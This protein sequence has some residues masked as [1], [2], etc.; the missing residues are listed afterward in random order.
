[1]TEVR[2]AASPALR[3]YQLSDNLAAQSGQVFLTG[4]QALVRLLL[5]QKAQDERQGLQTAGFVSGYRGSPLG[6]VDQQLWKAKKFLEKAEVNFLP[7]INEDLAA[8]AC[9]GVQRVA[10]DPKRTVDGVFAM[11]YGKGPG[12][13]RSGDALKHG[14]VY[15]TAKQGGVL[16]VCGDDHGC[17]SSS[18]PHQSD[19]ALQAWSMPLVHPGNVAEYL[20]FG[21]YGWALSRFS[22]AWV[23]FKAISEV[24]ESG[25]TVDLD[26]VP[27]DF[28]LPVDH[29]PPTDLHIRSVDLPSL[30]LE[31]RLAHK[32]D[33]VLAF[34]KINSIDK[35]IVVSP[36]A[37]LGI[38]TV[39]KAHYDF[40]E[41]LRRLDLDPNA[42]AAA[43]VRVYKVGLVYPLEPTRI[44]EF[45]QGL[46]DML[47][48]EE[49][50]PVVE[51]QIK[52]LLYHLPD[53]QRPRVVGKSDEHGAAVLS[54]LGELR[55]SRIMPTVAD[56]L[57][58]LNPALDRRHLVVD[59]LTPCLLSNSAD[60]VRRQ[61]YFCSGCPHNTSTKLPEGSRALAGIGCH[62]MASWMERGTS[63]L[64]QMG[65]EGVDWAA[66][67]RFTTEK[68]VFQNL[69][70][71]TYYHSGYLAIRQAI[72][73][74]ANIT[75]KI[76]YNDA[77][78]MTGGQPVDGQTSVPQIARQ[79]EAEGVKRLV[80]VSDEIGKYD[81]HHGLFPAGTTFHDR[82]ELDAVQRE[83]REIQGVTVLIYD[84][85]CAAEKR[86][87]RKKG[88]FP[89]P[90]KRIFINESVCEGCG[91]CGQASNCLSVVPVET[92]FG[93]KRAIE[94][95]SCNKDFS[96]VNGFCPSFVSVHGAKLKKRAGAA[97]GPADLARE[98]AT[99]QPPAAWA[100]TGP[101]DMLVT[102]VGGTGVVTVGALVT[103]AAHLEGKQSSVLDFM[104]FAQKGGA[105]LSFVRVA[106]TQD[107]LNQV[108]IDTQQAD[109]LL[110]CDMVV[111]ASADALATVKAGRT[112]ILANTHELPTAAFVRN[113]DASLQA[114]S[115]LAKMRHA[116]G[117]EKALLTSIDAQDIAQRLMGDTMPSNIV[118][119]GACWQRG[120]VPVSFEALMRA[121]ELNGVAVENNKT[122]F[123]LGR[124]AIAAPEALRRLAGEQSGSAVQWFN[125]DQL[126][127]KDG[128]PGLI[129]R[130]KAFLTEYQDA[131]Y[132][133]RYEALVQRVRAAEAALG[134]AGKGLRLTKAVA[135]YYAKLLA[136]KDEY[137]VA[138]LYT[139]GKF[140]AALKAQFEDW[141]HLSFHMAPPLIAK[142]GADGR[143]KKV[144]LGSWTF[145][146][147]KT[148]AKFKGL[149]GGA[150][151][152]FGRTEERRIERQLIR[153]YEALVDELLAGLS[154]E[155]LDIAIKLARLPEGIRG[156]GHVKL[157]NVVTVRA[158]WKD[159]LDRF[160]G[161]AVEAP[162]AVVPL[163]KA[164]ER[165]KGVAEL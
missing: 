106:P 148:L 12:V 99:I 108:R 136:I 41:V 72:A 128:Q 78:A 14:N 85:T 84:Q 134:D 3:A 156:Y 43:G 79:V 53:A 28:E 158:Q 81:G 127:D 19:L 46:T 137:E 60:A 75:Y 61:P 114:D 10:L 76:L 32:I 126:D 132:A 104:G 115:L 120:L 30:E 146:A 135:R 162:I 20:E 83:L 67:S 31:S 155:K 63:G 37:S 26:A 73:A 8:T 152:L 131:A 153:D 159:L 4:T 42:L 68:H 147:L 44:R 16:V 90:N 57:A 55:P 117:E 140:E 25:M 100:W 71:G 40:M 111:G 89:D 29:T 92:D 18:T 95:S 133:S 54:A 21:L 97:F 35:H 62:F 124:L 65:A 149:R 59:F 11:W 142:P 5:A 151:D 138:R 56:W 39:G 45:A 129:S 74:K 70:D 141:D 163:A 160:H 1:M 105:V 15:G 123:A 157:A 109:V 112:V 48:I 113:P 102:G 86:R 165:V 110:A 118:M 77:V 87:R 80:V 9:L 139:D 125:F 164:P 116:V 130:R 96:C 51:R 50:A 66:H 101:F 144:E 154:A 49:K 69:G 161:R 122:A 121:I 119:L 17:V 36:R 22:G 82:S 58:R 93:R 6:M 38:V 47:V 88:E 52:E 107:L 91:D 13:D 24:V 23:G 34:A 145:K 98:I 64:I 94:Q 7:A 2:P 27:L 33:A 143:A 150:L 103:M